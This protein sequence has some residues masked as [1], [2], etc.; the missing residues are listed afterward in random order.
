MLRRWGGSGG[1][2]RS[3]PSPHR[4]LFAAAGTLQGGNGFPLHGLLSMA[5]AKDA[6]LQ[7]L[8][9][10]REKALADE[11]RDIQHLHPADKQALRQSMR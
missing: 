2:R 5:K 11:R 7:A 3:E 10:D 1:V 6:A 9:F 4:A 8:L